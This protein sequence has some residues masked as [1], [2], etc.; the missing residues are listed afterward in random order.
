M[1]RVRSKTCISSEISSCYSS[2][3][4]PSLQN[5]FESQVAIFCSMKINTVLGQPHQKLCCFG[6]I[7]WNGTKSLSL[8]VQDVSLPRPFPQTFPRLPPI[9]Q[10]FVQE[11]VKRFHIYFGRYVFSYIGV[12][13]KRTGRSIRKDVFSDGR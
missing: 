8:F 13:N 4:S 10:S 11:V 5:N 3:L 9:Y 1:G 2:P 7:V 6:K 12:N